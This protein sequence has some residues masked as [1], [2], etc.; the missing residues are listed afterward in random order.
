MVIEA[1][2][3]GHPNA[4][5]GDGISAEFAAGGANGLLRE[6]D[7]VRCCTADRGHERGL[8]LLDEILSGAEDARLESSR[9]DA[10]Q[11]SRFLDGQLIVIRHRERLP[12]NG[13]HFPEKLVDRTKGLCFGANHFRIGLGCGN[14]F[15]PRS[16]IVI[17]GVRKGFDSSGLPFSP[18][19]QGGIDDD[20]GEPGR[21]RGATLE[22]SE[23]LIG[24]EY[25]VLNG[26]LCVFLVS[27][28]GVSQCDKPRT[29]SREHFLNCFP[30]MSCRRGRRQ[31]SGLRAGRQA[32]GVVRDRC[33][34]EARECDE[35]HGFG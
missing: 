14:S 23:M 13:T 3:A 21:D 18:D 32:R 12:E 9:R 26:V 25:C 10:E 16:F 28:N 30:V 20:A 17:A 6:G 33:R 31:S 2:W 8:R 29:R 1:R 4:T 27:Q 34:V 7:S 35:V 5:S 11:G 24:R 19:H 15:D 22:A